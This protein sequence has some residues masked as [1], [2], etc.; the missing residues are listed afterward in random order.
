MKYYVATQIVN[1]NA[2]SLTLTSDSPGLSA[3]SAP[4]QIVIQ[5]RSLRRTTRVRAGCVQ[6]QAQRTCHMK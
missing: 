1:P 2:G 5:L 3:L 4:S 6:A